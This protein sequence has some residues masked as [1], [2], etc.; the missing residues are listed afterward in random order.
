MTIYLVVI[1]VEEATSPDSHYEYGYWVLGAFDTRDKAEEFCSVYRTRKVVE[2]V[3]N[4]TTPN[5]KLYPY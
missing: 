5:D 1:D 3:L 2:V 4:S